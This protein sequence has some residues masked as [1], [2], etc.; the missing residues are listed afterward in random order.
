MTTKYVSPFFKR[1]AFHC[2]CCEVY[3][4][5]DWYEVAPYDRPH[6]HYLEISPNFWLSFCAH[7]YKF[8]VWHDEKIIFPVS[9]PAPLPS[10]EMPEEVKADYLEARDVVASSPRAASALLRLS[11][12][13]LMT[14][15]GE[16]GEHLNTDIGNLVKKGLPVPIQKALDSV[17]VIGNNAVH[18]GELDL[19]DDAETAN[20]LF[21]LVNMIVEVM[22]A[23][24]K[25]VDRIF[26]KL[27]A[28]A[29]EQIK[30]RDA[31]KSNG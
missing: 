28:G 26:E 3:A 31:E 8:A 16:K 19:K 2:P 13:K 23:Q 15:L 21:R 5:Q 7:C 18:P 22:I 10:G 20:A 11:I 9:T 27:P 24:P 4:N 1:R 29:K 6:S 25:E 17:R 30:N 12:Q 14:S